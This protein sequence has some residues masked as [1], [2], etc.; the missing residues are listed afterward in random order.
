MF[1]QHGDRII[2]SVY[3][4][5]LRTQLL[6]NS[7]TI[8]RRIKIMIRNTKSQ[9]LAPKSTQSS[10][11]FKLFVFFSLLEFWPPKKNYFFVFQKWTNKES[12]IVTSLAIGKALFNCTVNYQTNV[13]FCTTNIT[14]LLLYHTLASIDEVIDNR[15]I[16]VQCS[17]FLTG[18]LFVSLFL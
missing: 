12:T 18:K 8:S 14:N 5:Q 11:S 10:Q 6:F 1:R 13:L 15:H 2:Q 4:I 9:S 16:T 7:P 3:R 17:S